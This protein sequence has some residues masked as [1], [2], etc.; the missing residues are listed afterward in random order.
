LEI[1]INRL[2]VKKTKL[3]KSIY[4]SA[5]AVIFMSAFLVMCKKEK[6][7]GKIEQSVSFAINLS[8]SKN[9]SA[10]K[11]ALAYHLSDAKKIVLSIQNND[12]TATSYT[13]TEVKIYKMNDFYI[14]QKLMLKTGDYSL[15][16]FLLLDSTGNTIYAAPMAGSQETQ[17]VTHPLPISFNVTKDAS[18][19]I[20]VEVLST[21][22]KSPGDFGLVNFPISEVSVNNFLIA[23][24]DRES[25][26]LLS[27]V[28]TISNDSYSYVQTLDTI[29]NNIVTVRDSLNS[30]IYTLTIEK[31]GY[32]TY[33]HT[34]TKD[35]LKLFNGE[36]DHLPLLV[37]LE[38]NPNIGTVTDIDGNVYKTVKINNQWWM[39]ENLKVTHFRNGDPITRGT[40]IWVPYGRCDCFTQ[41]FDYNYDSTNSVIYGRIYGWFVVSD[42]RK[43]APT[44]WRVA[45]D[46]D[47]LKLASFFLY[48]SDKLKEKGTAHWPNTNTGTNETGFTALPGGMISYSKFYGLGLSGVWWGSRDWSWVIYNSGITHMDMQESAAS[49]RCVKE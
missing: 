49:V 18:T 21:E 11:S 39:A 7:A 34:F 3:M 27:A 35:S 38:R 5:I 28:L 44:G 14:S 17:N 4:F 6:D 46:G 9:V 1:L 42:S 30:N 25:N 33:N 32:I 43:I 29:A 41:Y 20:N 15:T 22:N 31:Y 13:S 8:N 23:V 36:E 10:L 37:E 48:N 19:P 2:T 26:S 47:W 16:E 45:N 12:G 24:T 40:S